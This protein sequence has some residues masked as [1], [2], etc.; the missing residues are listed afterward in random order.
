MSRRWSEP[1]AVG[2]AG[3]GLLVI[4]LAITASAGRAFNWG[5]DFRAYYDAALRFVT[6]GT[7]YQSHTLA[8][9]F[10]PGPRGLYLYSPWPALLTVPLTSLSFD[11]AALVWAGM[12]VLLLALTCALMPVPRNVRLLVF[13]VAT[14]SQPVLYDL[15]LG[16]VS[17]VVTLLSVVAWRWLD[18]PLS[19]LALAIS[20]TVRPTMAVVLAWWALRLR[21]RPIAWTLA[22]AL[23]GILA[24]LP[25]APLGLWIDWTT[26]LRNVTD[27]MGT[28]SNVDAG[29]AVLLVNGPAWLAGTALFAGYLVAGLAVLLSLR[30]D[31]DLSFVVMLMA[32]LLLSPLLWAHYL[33]QLLVPAA[34]LAARGRR[35]GLLLPLLGW[36]PAAAMPLIALA[37]M[38]APFLAPDSGPRTAS[39]FDVLAHRG[40]D[41]ALASSR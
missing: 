39:I 5:Y 29:S 18:R 34:F 19:A 6:S 23:V 9:P 28:P 13:G 40:R 14:F 10:Q 4:A 41:P 21:W 11:A 3:L 12:R 38:L 35:W 33:T 2:V 20:L 15:D 30:R 26:V 27:V 36:L 22:L 16:N 32:T 7:P 1:I 17:I 31:R 24:S 8:G 37:G 25:F